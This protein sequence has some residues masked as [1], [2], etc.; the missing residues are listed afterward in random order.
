MTIVHLPS[1]PSLALLAAMMALAVAPGL[2]SRPLLDDPVVADATVNDGQWRID[3]F[4]DGTRSK[5]ARRISPLPDGSHV[6]VGLANPPGG[7]IS[8]DY[9]HLVLARHGAD[10]EL[11][12]WLAP[13]ALLPVDPF[14]VVVDLSSAPAV[15]IRGL[16]I[17][18]RHIHVLVD[19]VFSG[20]AYSHLYSFAF[21]GALHFDQPVRPGQGGGLAYLQVGTT[22]RLFVFT[23]EFQN[24]R[25]RAHATRFD[26]PADGLPQEVGDWDLLPPACLHGSCRILAAT[27]NGHDRFPGLAPRIYLVGSHAGQ[28]EDFLVMRLDAQGQPDNGFALLSTFVL[29]FDR[30]GSSLVDL[31]VGVAVR[32]RQLLGGQVA[33]DVYVTGRVEQSCRPGTAVLALDGTGQPL[34]GFGT[35]G[36]LLFGGSASAGSLCN[37]TNPRNTLINAPLVDGNRLLLVGHR[38]CQGCPSVAAL[39][40]IDLARGQLVWQAELPGPAHGG[41]TR[42]TN[43]LGASRAAAGRYLL[44][45]TTRYPEDAGTLV[46]LR[47]RYQFA[48]LMVREDRLH[49]HGFD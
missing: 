19:Q 20:Q 22:G 8:G 4:G 30:P 26:V 17:G 29:G 28:N 41:T 23:S 37:G 13:P 42:P 46:L 25:W 9:R 18:D 36:A 48:T 49:G 24:D 5:L 32:N 45:G 10:G 27:S 35:A 47:G 33:E 44:A 40:S 38:Q 6:V 31:A 39:A 16:A 21:H 14:H 11:L 34:Q 15:D 3:D 43:L 12:P 7:A 2:A 1:P